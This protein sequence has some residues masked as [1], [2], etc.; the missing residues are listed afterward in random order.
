MWAMTEAPSRCVCKLVI[1]CGLRAFGL[2]TMIGSGIKMM[3]C[4]CTAG[5]DIPPPVRV[6]LADAALQMKRLLG[7]LALGAAD[8][9]K[10]SA[11]FKT[12]GQVTH[13]D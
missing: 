9:M 5:D 10:W 13:F 2:V 7:D 6:P 8:Q 12:T 11:T 1:G 3:G 4:R